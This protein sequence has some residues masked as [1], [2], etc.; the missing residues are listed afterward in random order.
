M[1]GM[2]CDRHCKEPYVKILDEE[3]ASGV[4]VTLAKVK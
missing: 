4:R 3:G 1:F 2:C